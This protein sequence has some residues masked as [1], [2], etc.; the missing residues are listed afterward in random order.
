MQR[1]R[2]SYFN[3]SAFICVY[4][5]FQFDR[6]FACEVDDNIGGIQRDWDESTFAQW[7]KDHVTQS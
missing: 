3:L 4:L 7:L 2:S 6:R 1:S 5:R